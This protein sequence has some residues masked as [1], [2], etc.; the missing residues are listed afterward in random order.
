MASTFVILEICTN[1]SDILMERK[2]SQNGSE[3]HLDASVLAE[4]Q[5]NAAEKEYSN[6]WKRTS[7]LTAG[8]QGIANCFDLLLGG[9]FFFLQHWVVDIIKET[10][11]CKGCK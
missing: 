11:I 5:V 8:S 2:I 4:L 7:Q 6:S 10:E 9:F 1:R 3:A